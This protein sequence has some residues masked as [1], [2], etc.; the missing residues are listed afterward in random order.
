MFLS[1]K[2]K[3]MKAAK[4]LF[5]EYGYGETSTKRI[6]QKAK[7]NEVTIFRLFGSKSKLLQE[8]ITNFAY[9][10]NIIDKIKAELT[11]DITQDLYIFAHVYYQ[12]LE[13]NISLYKIQIK[14]ISEEGVTFS[15]S[16]AY[17]EYM[18]DYLETAKENRLFHGDPQMVAS[19]M[20]ALIFGLFSFDVYN[21]NIYT[22]TVHH[23]SIINTYV[24]HIYKLYC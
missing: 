16:V 20:I 1:A 15:N 18:K 7:V 6:A 21:Q 10:G 24:D 9:E 2:E 23:E 17:V 8:I 3:I 22:S 4:V 19:S 14:E 13:N 5:S 11:G 12:F